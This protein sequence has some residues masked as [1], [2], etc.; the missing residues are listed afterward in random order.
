MLGGTLP[1]RTQ[2]V[3]RNTGGSMWPQP[4]SRVLLSRAH[5]PATRVRA[6]GAPLIQ[7]WCGRITLYGGWGSAVR[8][9]RANLGSDGRRPRREPPCRGEHDRTTEAGWGASPPE[10]TP[11][12]RGKAEELAFVF[13]QD[14]GARRQLAS[15]GL[16]LARPTRVRLGNPVRGGA[17]LELIEL[18]L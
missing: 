15:L 8:K 13:W 1:G 3:L 5:L 12:P 10:Y 18:I 6:A 2:G 4:F 9:P 7:G 17:A 16:P 11:E 14:K